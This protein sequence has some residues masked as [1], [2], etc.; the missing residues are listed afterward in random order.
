M[1][2][3]WRTDGRTNGGKWKIEQCSVGPETAKTARTQSTA[4]AWV[5]KND[6]NHNCHH[7][8][9][10]SIQ[11]WLL[12]SKVS[13]VN[14]QFATEK[15]DEWYAQHIAVLTERVLSNKLTT[16][17]M[18]ICNM[19]QPNGYLEKPPPPK[20]LSCTFSWSDHMASE[21]ASLCYGR[22]GDV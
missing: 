19:T 7:F 1:S 2:R 21:D 14:F 5:S 18:I 10:S 6:F 8:T 20:W 17:V 22:W 13:S 4:F 11:L 15:P 12:S 16:W 3:L 9:S